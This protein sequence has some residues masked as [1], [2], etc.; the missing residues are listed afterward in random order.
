MDDLIES[1]INQ[2]IKYCYEHH[3]DS[4]TEIALVKMY[5]EKDWL[6]SDMYETCFKNVLQNTFYK[7]VFDDEFCN[8]LKDQSIKFEQYCMWLF[9]GL[10]HFEDLVN[11][12]FKNM[13]A[14]LH[15]SVTNDKLLLEKLNI[16]GSLSESAIKI[17]RQWRESVSNPAYNLCRKRLTRE[18]QNLT[19]CEKIDL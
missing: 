5:A 11:R 12:A 8:H 9:S 3:L 1:Y 4:G 19:F 17:Q 10:R 18:F 13:E 2:L 16:I 7:Y 6:Y 14:S 15:A